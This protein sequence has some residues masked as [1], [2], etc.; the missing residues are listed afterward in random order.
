MKHVCK[1]CLEKYSKE[2][3]FP[4]FTLFG[5][6]LGTLGSLFFG[7]IAMIPSI[8]AGAAA[9]VI[10][11][12]ICGSIDDLN[13]VKET[14][15]WDKPIQPRA[16]LKQFE[17]RRSLEDDTFDLE[18]ENQQSELPETQ[19]ILND[20]DIGDYEFSFDTGRYSLDI[21]SSFDVGEADAGFGESGS[22]ESCDAGGSEGSE[23]S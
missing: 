12:R 22:G 11:C 9:D 13:E 6:I 21:G 2:K 4:S 15:R 23:G 20:Q 19:F 16:H 18:L 14:D 8:F 1:N 7:P 5:G 10:K 3:N 17:G